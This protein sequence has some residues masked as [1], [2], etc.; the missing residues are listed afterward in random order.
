MRGSELLQIPD[1]YGIVRGRDGKQ[2]LQDEKK[3]R[4]DEKVWQDDEQEWQDEK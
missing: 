3:E 4:Q 1:T 2:E